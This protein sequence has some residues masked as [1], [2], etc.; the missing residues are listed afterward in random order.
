MKRVSKRFDKEPKEKRRRPILPLVWHLC[1]ASSVSFPCSSSSRKFYFHSWRPYSVNNFSK[2]TPASLRL[3]ARHVIFNHILSYILCWFFLVLVLPI[4][5]G[6]K[7]LKSEAQFLFFLCIP[8]SNW[9]CA[10]HRVDAK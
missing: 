3:T 2:I 5:G 10:E 8:Q 4:E 6:W 7:L 1:Y 9:Y